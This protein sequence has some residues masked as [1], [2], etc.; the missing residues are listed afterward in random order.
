MHP[1]PEPRKGNTAQST[2]MMN[3]GQD[4][5][6]RYRKKLKLSLDSLST[7]NDAFTT[8]PFVILSFCSPALVA[9]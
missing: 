6:G 4:K 7:T 1:T 9:Y 8:P 2:I 3:K 5:R